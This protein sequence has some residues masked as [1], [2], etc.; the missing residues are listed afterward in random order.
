MFASVNPEQ[1]ARWLI[2][3]LVKAVAKQRR[4]IRMPSERTL[5]RCAAQLLDE[6]EPEEGRTPRPAASAS[7]VIAP[8]AWPFPTSS[9]P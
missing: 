7:S 3:P 4:K 1:Y 5:L 8:A 9:R 2:R 6:K